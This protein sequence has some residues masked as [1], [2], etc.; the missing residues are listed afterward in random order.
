[1]IDDVFVSHKSLIRIMTVLKLVL[2]EDIAHPVV[3][4]FVVMYPTHP[5]MC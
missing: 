4:N 1:M 3:L 5:E 2:K